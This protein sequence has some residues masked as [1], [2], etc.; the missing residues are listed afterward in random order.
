[1]QSPYDAAEESSD[2]NPKPGAITS[3]ESQKKNPKRISVFIDHAFGLGLHQDVLL[4]HNLYTGRLLDAETLQVLIHADALLRAKEMALQY[5]GH[6]ARSSHEVRQ[7]L[8]QSGFDDGI[9]D[10]VT[11]RLH[12]LGY[13]DDRSFTRHFV[14]D[15][16]RA[17]G[18]GP[19]RLQADLYRMGIGSNLIEETLQAELQDDDLFTAA[20][21]QGRK[22]WKR[23]SRESDSLKKRK[24]LYDYLLRRGHTHETTQQVADQLEKEEVD[25]P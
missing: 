10:Q 13:L 20:L 7:K 23:L 18:Y 25:T 17:R 16:F 19:R 2:Q 24:K 15:R 11:Q 1:M 6:R 5:L 14:R 4:Q 3:L 8:S 22:R 9:I 12:E 21:E